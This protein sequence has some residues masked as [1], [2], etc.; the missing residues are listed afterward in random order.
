M[1]SKTLI[2][3]FFFLMEIMTV[4]PTKKI[5]KN[6]SSHTRS[7]CDEASIEIIC[8]DIN[9]MHTWFYSISIIYAF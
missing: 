8:R 3:I 5:K 6:T 7:A 1:F 2:Q 4:D 9:E